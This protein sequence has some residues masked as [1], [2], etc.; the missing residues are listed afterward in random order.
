[1][2]LYCL[3]KL[4]KSIQ[5]MYNQSGTKFWLEPGSLWRHNISTIGNIHQLFHGY[6]IQGQCHSHFSTVNPALEFFQSADST[7]EV[8]SLVRTQILDTKYLVQDEIRRDCHVKHSYRVIVI[9]RSRFGSK[10]IPLAGK[11]Q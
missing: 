2:F 7:Y 5:L 4:S 6:R 11:I 10:T 1:M 3:I 9:I 8:N